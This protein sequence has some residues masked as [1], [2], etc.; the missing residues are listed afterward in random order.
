[1][2]LNNIVYHSDRVLYLPTY[3]TYLLGVG[4]VLPELRC[5]TS[6]RS[7]PI[8]AWVRGFRYLLTQ[9]G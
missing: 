1:M 9:D 6:A 8:A 7:F 4:S 3:F 2:A 5:G